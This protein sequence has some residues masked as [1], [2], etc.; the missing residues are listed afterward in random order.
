M[1]DGFGR[2]A[3]HPGVRAYELVTD[4]MTKKNGEGMSLVL[5]KTTKSDAT[6]PTISERDLKKA[7]LHFLVNCV[8]TGKQAYSDCAEYIELRS[9]EEWKRGKFEKAIDELRKIAAFFEKLENKNE[10]N[11]F[12]LAEVYLLI[13]QLYQYAEWYPESIE[14][15]SKS[16]LANDGNSLPYNC[17]AVSYLKTG[18]IHNAIR[19][20]EQEL[21]IDEGNYSTYLK[22]SEL[23]G[24]EGKLEKS[25]ECLKK[26]LDRDPENIQGLHQLIRHYEKYN[27]AIDVGLL[28]KRLLGIAAKHTWTTAA[29]RAYHLDAEKRFAEALDFLWA[30]QIENNGR[31]SPV[32]HLVKTVLYDELNRDG[33]LKTELVAFIDECHLRQQV[34]HEYIEEFVLLFGEPHATRLKK[35]L[36]ADER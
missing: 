5:E 26:L 16:V 2:N 15:L 27:P 28:R 36:Q 6:F 10:E 35:K 14:W 3:F 20:F 32:I 11:A 31:S 7:R 18:N 9:Y 12:D 17:M 8:I 4:C 13:G 30:W 1:N 21:A 22:L 29:I 25:E 19:C 24:R 34:M 23:Y 33:E